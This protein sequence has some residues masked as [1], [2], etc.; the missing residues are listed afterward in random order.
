MATLDPINTESRPS[1]SGSPIVSVRDLSVEFATSHG[2]QRVVSDVSLDLHPGRILGI[3]GESGS[4]KSVT[5]LAMMRLLP[6][7]GSRVSSGSIA[8]DGQDVLALEGKELAR[9]RGNTMAMIFQEPM[10]SLN[11]A[12]TIGEQ[13]SETVRRHKGLSRKDAWK[14]AVQS[15]DEVGIPNA[16]DRAKRYPHEFS[17]GM[18]QRAMIAMAISCQPKVLIADEPTTALD[19]TIQAQIL[20]LLR[21]MCRDHGLAMMFITHNM[22]VVADLCDDVTVMYA[23]QI[24]ER[25]EIHEIFAS[26][27]QPYTE[28]LLRAVPKLEE[29]AELASIPGSTPPPWEM[30]TGCRFA[31]RCPYAVTA[32]TEAPIPLMQLDDRRHR[33]IRVNELSLRGTA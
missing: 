19:V 20:E 25:A 5:S 18:R 17:G 26:P 8:V 10:T 4:G 31:P 1:A 11:P 29:R 15:L 13:I 21:T 22:G 23:G 33:C 14:R 30:P 2:W 6:K 16:A 24:V 12:F 3:V 9:M 32:C 28:G 27:K 7:Q